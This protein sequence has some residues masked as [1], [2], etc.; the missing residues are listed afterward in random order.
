[1]NNEI[2]DII[3]GLKRTIQLINPKEKQLLLIA[4]ITMAFTGLLTNLPAVII[5]QLV[6]QMQLTNTFSFTQALPYILFI[7]L[8]L[9]IREG[10][11]VIRKLIIE[12]IATQTEKKQT[13]DI[14]SHLLKADLNFLSSQQI[15][16][17]HGKVI[18][19]IQ[20]LIRMIKLTFMDFT[21]AIFGALAAILLALY[22]KPLIA[23]VMILV[24]PTSLYIIFKQISSQK[25]IRVSLLRGKEQIDG[26]VVEM[27]GGIEAIRTADTT[28]H[29]L[30]RIEKIAENLRLKEIKHHLAMAFFDATKQLNEGIFYILVVSTAIFFSTQGI[31]TQGDI[32]VYSILFVSITNPLKEIHRI[33]DQ[34]HEGS[35][36]VND[37][38]ELLSQPEDKSFL[39]TNEVSQELKNQS[40]I[41]EIKGL[42]F[43]FPNQPNKLLSNIS[44]TVKQGEKIGIV[45]ASGCGK[46]TLVK[47][48][49]RLHHGYE[50]SVHFLDKDLQDLSRKEIAQKIAYVP[51]KPYIF[52]GTIKDNIIY[53]ASE[54]ISHQDI[55]NAAKKANIYEEII[56]NLGGLE[57]KVSENGSNLSGGQK[58]RLAI[59]RLILKSPDIFIFD[60]ATSA[61][62]NTNEETIQKNINEEFKDKTMIIIAH[63]LSTL[64]NTDRIIVLDKGDIIQQGSFNH[65]AKQKGLFKQFLEGK[66]N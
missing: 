58:Q 62:D 33:L 56:N 41:L 40:H 25:G 7:F 38:Y 15:G 61:L 63:R 43:S 5:G 13:V 42:S 18:R 47:I 44:L 24:I 20:G 45:G 22:Q 23:T 16:S 19:S 34:A 10:L 1:M 2:S 55:I 28:G 54:N 9:I 35:I 66:E 59:A 60:E 11:I 57:G 65:L 36:L 21:P 53:E 26:T 12:N 3:L 31:I 49:L 29:E 4:V 64:I 50:G 6:D 27:L 46:S 17:L 48:L 52:S 39:P 37:L 14:I 30:K 32:L 51:Q 8:I